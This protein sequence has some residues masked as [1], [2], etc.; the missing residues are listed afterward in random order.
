VFDTQGILNR[1]P[2]VAITDRAGLAGIA[3]WLNT[4]LLKEKKIDKSHPGVLKIKEWID[5]Q[6]AAGR[7]NVISDEEMLDLVKKHLPEYYPK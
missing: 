3:F 6:F 7:V 2:D 5:E 1:P 4:Q